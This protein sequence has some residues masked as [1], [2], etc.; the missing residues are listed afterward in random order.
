MFSFKNRKISCINFVFVYFF[1]MS[2]PF[3]TVNFPGSPIATAGSCKK[4]I[5]LLFCLLFN[6]YNEYLFFHSSYDCY[7]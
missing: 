3:S 6:N 1:M 7:F 4:H 5:S 2:A